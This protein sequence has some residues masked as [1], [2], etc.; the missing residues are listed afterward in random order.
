MKYF[1]AVKIV[2]AMCFVS[3]A[4]SIPISADAENIA[5][6][7]Y[8]D[9]SADIFKTRQAPIEFV[10]FAGLWLEYA[11]T[12]AVGD[13]IGGAANA[14]NA[15]FHAFKGL[16]FVRTKPVEFIRIFY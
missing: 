7:T 9:K 4:V 2:A 10:V 12:G 13:A 1:Q 6:A 14:L 8:I 16:P 3:P 15:A 5:P 11:A